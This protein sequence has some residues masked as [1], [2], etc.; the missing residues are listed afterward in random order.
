MGKPVS[1]TIYAAISYS[2]Q[3]PETH[4]QTINLLKAL[5]QELGIENLSK[6][7]EPDLILH[8]INK[9]DKNPQLFV[10]AANIF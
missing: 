5:E 4:A 10:K 9:C 3:N 7:R 2:R 1:T 6:M 8:R